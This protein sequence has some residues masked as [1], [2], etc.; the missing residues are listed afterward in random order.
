MDLCSDPCPLATF[1][2]LA[3][4]I[5][6]RSARSHVRPNEDLENRRNIQAKIRALGAKLAAMAVLRAVWR[7]IWSIRAFSREVFWL[8][9]PAFI[10]L[11]IATPS[12]S[13]EISDISLTSGVQLKDKGQFETLLK[14]QDVRAA[15]QYYTDQKIYVD[16]EGLTQ[17]NF[18]STKT[19]G[20]YSPILY[21]HVISPNQRK[22][23]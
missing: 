16:A 23:A 7:D 19:N 2:D 14:D 22:R 17:F 15:I 11:G 6:V 9:T 8:I 20:F 21:P 12:N 5:S 10:V 1:R 13:Q 3:G 18:R 4:H